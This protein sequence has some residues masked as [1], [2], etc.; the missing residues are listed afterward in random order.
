V[1]IDDSMVLSHLFFAKD[2]VFIGEWNDSNLNTIVHVLKSFFL[3]S[4]LKINI[5]KSELMGIG[6]RS[7]E[8]D[9]AARVVGCSTLSTPFSYLGVT[10][11]G[12]MSR[13]QTWDVVVRKL[14][15][16]LSRWKL[17]TLSVGGD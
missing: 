15:S 1:P 14:S 11:G 3:V 2:A 17:K 13:I 10:I 5:H 12:R 6:V 16:R 9:R 8:V 7:D 4:G